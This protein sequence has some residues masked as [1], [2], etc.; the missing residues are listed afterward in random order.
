MDDEDDVCLQGYNADVDTDNDDD[1]DD[2]DPENYNVES[3]FRLGGRISGEDGQELKP[4]PVLVKL[5]EERVKWH[6]LSKAKELGKSVHV[7]WKKVRISQD[8]TRRERRK[9]II[10]RRANEEE[11]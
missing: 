2:D 1:D 7:D 3:V 5:G 11:S 6:I 10:K 9:Q 8:L 4:R